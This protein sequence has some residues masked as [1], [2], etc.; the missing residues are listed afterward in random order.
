M[1]HLNNEKPPF[2]I[3][4]YDPEGLFSRSVTR[5]M[6]AR[7]L[8]NDDGRAA[9]VTNFKDASPV[10]MIK[11]NYFVFGANPRIDIIHRGMVWQR[12][13]MRAGTACV[14]NRSQVSGGGRKPRPQK[15]TG[16]AR[17]GSIRAPHYRGGGVVHGPIPRSYKYSLPYKVQK[18]GLRALLSCRYAQGD[19]HIVENFEN[20]SPYEEDMLPILKKRGWTR[21]TL[22]DGFENKMLMT[23]TAAMPK[24]MVNNCLDI[25]VLDILNTDKVIM[26]LAAVE[27][28]ENRLCEDNR[29]ITDPLYQFL[30]EEPYKESHLKHL[31]EERTIEYSLEKS[32][33]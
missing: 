19:V 22:I 24:V 16:K 6:Q 1:V 20:L 9:L 7:Y 3:R 4:K 21:A 23:A 26:S 11:L 33:T 17:Q 31:L 10:G 28:I 29:I 30:T 13:C 18:M 12:A 27:F 5:F 32:S 8:E 25:N 2:N 14:K 15:G